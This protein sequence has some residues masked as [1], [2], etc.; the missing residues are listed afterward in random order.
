MD[1]SDYAYAPLYDPNG[2]R[3]LSILPGEGTEPIC[4]EIFQ[5][6]LGQHPAYEA[7]SY[8]WGEA[9]F[10]CTIFSGSSRLAVSTNLHSALQR[11][12]QRNSR[13][14][15]W[16]DA[17]CINQ[18]DVAE[19]SCQV[20][21]MREIFQSAER[22]VV[23]I[24]EASAT[25]DLAIN[26]LCNMAGK[27]KRDKSI[28]AEKKEHRRPPEGHLVY[29]YPV[30]HENDYYSYFKSDYNKHWAALD[31]LLARP[32]WSRA[33]VVQEVWSASRVILQCGSRIIGWNTIQKALNYE[34]GWDDMGQTMADMDFAR[35]ENWNRLKRRYGL[36]IHIAGERVNG[37]TL[38][39]LLWNTWDREA[40]DPRD[41]VFS[42]LELVGEETRSG[43]RPDYA[44]PVKQVYVEAARDIL[45]S[46]G[47]MDILLAAN[48]LDRTD[49][50]PSWVPD[51]RREAN[52]H[53]PTLFVN[54]DRL[55]TMYHSGSTDA[56]V[57][58]E[59]G[60]MASGKTEATFGFDDGSSVLIVSA[61]RIDT[62]SELAPEFRTGEDPPMLE[63]NYRWRRPAVPKG[64]DSF[65]ECVED[66]IQLAS[67]AL[68]IGPNNEW[69][70]MRRRRFLVT[71]KGR[72]GIGHHRVE[73]GD[74]VWIIKGCSYP[75]ILRRGD[76]DGCYGLVGEAYVHG[77]MAGEAVGPKIKGRSN[78]FGMLY[79]E[80]SDSE[81]DEE[82]RPEEVEWQEIRIR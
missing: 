38:S 37:S 42:V 46:Q 16:I 67:N 12:R 29:G 43:L 24:G 68:G 9:D 17:I 40:A 78:P 19:R 10:A 52:N 76:D 27:E 2:I 51:W 53:R 18:V 28:D 81:Q 7:L 60:F 66:A 20:G 54:R 5:T 14:T 47:K 74:E 13:R 62:V 55:H 64:P 72:L 71:E 33:W 22:V 21:K 59:Y 41:K 69:N 39:D 45:E 3:I 30:L 73:K 31:E 50:L 58:W 26:F 8:A 63:I 44:K 70:L 11:L 23:W 25:S 35:V 4:V 77:V 36:A 56:V 79:V 61:V 34:E 48:G 82:V 57:T 32:W 75:L 6:T 1:S 15:M 80:E 49:G 65:E